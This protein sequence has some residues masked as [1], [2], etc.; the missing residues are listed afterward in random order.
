[1]V[2][3][4]Q[5]PNEC[6]DNVYLFNS[7]SCESEFRSCRAMSGP[8]SCIVNFTIPQFIQRAKKLS[9]LH[10]VKSQSSKSNLDIDSNTI[11]F[12]SHH[13]HSKLVHH[14]QI[15]SLSASTV[16]LTI[17]TIEK[18][19]LQAYHDASRLMREVKACQNNKL[20]SLNDLSRLTSIQLQQSNVFEYSDQSQKELDSESDSD[21]SI[22]QEED[23]S[24]DE[25]YDEDL[26]NDNEVLSTDSINIS[27][28][29]YQGM[30]VFDTINPSLARS[31]FVININGMK[32]FLHKQ[33]AVWLLSKDKSTLSSDRLKRVMV[34]KKN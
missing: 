16:S 15:I 4:H 28:S 18:S 20:S 30:R 23:L 27:S 14:E 8:F 21:D 34:N 26:I 10:C 12:P 7:Q 33:T 17:E 19:I 9:Y 13:K 22:A 24:D 11:L 32:K 5:L 25:P 3:Q 31:Y 6:L 2:I 1:M 29:T